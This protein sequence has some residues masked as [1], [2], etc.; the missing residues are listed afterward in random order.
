MADRL[1]PKGAKMKQAVIVSGARSAVGRA[2][3][4]ALR[5]IHP[6]DMTAAAIGEAIGRAESVEKDEIEDVIIGCAMPEGTQGYNVARLSSMRAG[7]PETVPAQTVNRFCSRSEEH[8]S[9]LQSRQ[10]LVCR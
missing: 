9:E 10:Y 6:V 1:R 2:P 7:L 3:R 5:A 4:G 8:T